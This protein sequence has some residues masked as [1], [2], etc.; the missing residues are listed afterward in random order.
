MPRGQLAVLPL[1]CYSV[2]ILFTVAG[3]TTFYLLLGPNGVPLQRGPF[4][5]LLFLVMPLALSGQGEYAVGKPL[6]PAID[7]WHEVTIDQEALTLMRSLDQPKDQP[8]QFAIPV[9]VSLTPFNS[10]FTVSRGGETVW[11]LPLSSKGAL[12][13]NLILTPYELPDGAYIY[14]YDNDR[15]VVRGAFTAGSGSHT[16]PILPVPGDLMVLECH[17]PGGLIPPDAIGVS[18][19]AHDFAGFF[20]PPDTKDAYY[21]RS[22]ECEVD[23]LCSSDTTHHRVAGSVVRLLVAGIELCTGV[24]VNTTGNANKPYLLTANHCISNDKEAANTIFVFNYRSPVCGGPDISNMHSLTGSF[25]RA[26]GTETDFSLVELH[27]FP[28]IHFKPY[29]AGWDISGTAPSSAFTLHHP[30]GDMMKVSL[31]GRAPV[32]NS[33]PVPGFA[34]S[35]FWRVMLWD[36]GSTEP[37][38]SGAP[39]FDPAG[40]IRGTLTGGS[41]TCANPR[42]DYFA[43]VSMMFDHGDS[44]SSRLRPWLDPLSIGATRTGGRNPYQANLSQSDTLG[45]I[46]T[47]EGGMMS[48]YLLPG[49]GLSTGHNSDSLV[50]YAEYIPFAGSGELIWLRV[51]VAAAAPL[52]HADSIRFY[53]WHDSDTPG[54]VITSRRLRVSEVI[55]GHE[56]ELDFGGPV[57][58]SGPFYAGYRIYYRESLHQHQPLFGVTHSAPYLYPPLNSAFFSDGTSW[59]PFTSHPSYPMSVSLGIRA[60][61]VKNSLLRVPDTI[62]PPQ[63]GVQVFPNPF[64]SYITFRIVDGVADEL[65]LLIYDNAGLV[66]HAGHYSITAPGELTVELPPLLPGVY[67]YSLTAGRQQYSGTVIKSVIR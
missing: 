47:G 63:A 41:A 48:S 14:L 40:L 8:W 1:L 23:L 3:L 11:V 15:T 54:N 34:A 30:E 64:V 5:A 17:F 19:V 67:H 52:S 21:G 38:S 36:S 39:L 56:T 37:G 25:L 9:G 32:V 13:L 20:A 61:M 31:T 57:A 43:R 28:P 51:R 66:V 65:S 29:L 44:E 7:Q 6:F 4:I 46:T 10:G 2:Q 18:Q 62:R 33:Y 35:A 59:K 24:M 26:T 60:V 12:S 22:G 27:Q 58:L 50:S 42:N 53:L 49:W 16:L 55:S 45:G